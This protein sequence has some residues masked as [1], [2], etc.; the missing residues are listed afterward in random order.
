VLTTV[1]T[2]AA[3]PP[4]GADGDDPRLPPLPNR[5]DASVGRRVFSVWIVTYGLVGA[6]MAWILR[7]FIGTPTQEFTFFR[8]RD[9]NFF[10]GLLDALRAL[11][12]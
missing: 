5:T 1:F 4:R 7:P 12:Q 11:F 2:P 8:P 10:V 3:P 6:Q 9:A